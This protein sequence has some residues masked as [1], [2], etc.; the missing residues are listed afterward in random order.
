M[1]TNAELLLDTSAAIALVQVANE[2]HEWVRD[3]VRGRALG[4]AGHALIETSSVL[5]RLPGAQRVSAATAAR[6]IAVNFPRS[7]A[8]SPAAGRGALAAL[9]A[10]ETSGGAAYDGLVALAARA[11]V[12][13]VT[14]DRRALSTYSRPNVDVLML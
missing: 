1:P 11:G 12:R 13:L 4:L 7:H 14:C 8:L 5:T 3:A 6:I 10:A 2:Q 9:Q